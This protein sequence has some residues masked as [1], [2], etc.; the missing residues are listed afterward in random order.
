MGVATFLPIYHYRATA[1]GLASK[2]ASFRTR[3]ED[4]YR[5][6]EMKKVLFE[7]ML[8]ELEER[9]R[10]RDAARSELDM[11]KDTARN[12]YQRM[13]QAEADKS[14]VQ[15]STDCDRFLLV[16]IDGDSMPV[17]ARATNGLLSSMR[18]LNFWGELTCLV[19]R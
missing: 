8:A 17:R 7:E 19:S 5:G 13:V 18:D 3:V 2:M 16:L 6:D 12:Y 9:T 15:T 4:V 11:A 1:T 14:H 10:E